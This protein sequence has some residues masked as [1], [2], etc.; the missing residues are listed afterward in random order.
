MTPDARK[1]GYQP[2]RFSFNVKG[3]RCEACSGDGQIRVEMHF[4]PDVYAVSYTHLDVYKRQ[5]HDDAAASGEI[6]KHGRRGVRHEHRGPEQ[7]GKL[8]GALRN[9]QHAHH[10]A[11]ARRNEHGREQIEHALDEQ[12]GTLAGQAFAHGTD[13][14]EACLLYTSALALPP[15]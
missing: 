7:Q 14:P 2:G 10:T 6:R 1:R 12:E 4:L 13:D 5:E 9:G 11:D 3:G 8:N 15:A